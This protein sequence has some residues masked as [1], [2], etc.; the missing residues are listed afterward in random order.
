[1]NS[2]VS[3]STMSDVQLMKH[4]INYPVS[5]SMTI[6]QIQ[7]A[8]IKLDDDKLLHFNLNRATAA[9]PFTF[10][11]NRNMRVAVASNVF[12]AVDDGGQRCETT[13]RLMR[14]LMTAVEHDTRV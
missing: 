1:M 7:F 8:K 3:F 5:I 10:S 4:L 6:G 9:R 12:M 11:P 13:R 14:H 2:L